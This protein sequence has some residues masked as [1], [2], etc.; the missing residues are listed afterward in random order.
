MQDTISSNFNFLVLGANVRDNLF[1]LQV[2]DTKLFD[3]D[4]TLKDKWNLAAEEQW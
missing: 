3:V 1:M 4:E 2:L